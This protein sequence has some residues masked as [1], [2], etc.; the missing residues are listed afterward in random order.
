M[1]P[2]VSRFSKPNVTYCFIIPLEILQLKMIKE[3][4]NETETSLPKKPTFQ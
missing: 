1:L 3:H 4:F 2:D